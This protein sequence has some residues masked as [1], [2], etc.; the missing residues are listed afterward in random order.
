[1][2]F[3][4][5]LVG[6][7]KWMIRPG[8][9]KKYSNPFKDV[10]ELSAYAAERLHKENEIKEKD[11]EVINKVIELTKHC[12]ASEKFNNWVYLQDIT[13]EQLGRNLCYS[14]ICYNCFSIFFNNCTNIV[15]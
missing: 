13:E 3:A 4:S 7:A 10:T 9:S 2:S 11:Q 8:F 12:S 15:T 6:F 14:T 5:G 1:M